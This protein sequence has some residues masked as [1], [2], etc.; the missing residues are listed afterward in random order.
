MLPMLWAP[1]PG[2][3]NPRPDFTPSP[4]LPAERILWREAATWAEEFWQRVARDEQVSD[5]MRQCAREAGAFVTRMRAH[6]AGA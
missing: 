5:E 6:F 2:N 4:P 3:S 1:V